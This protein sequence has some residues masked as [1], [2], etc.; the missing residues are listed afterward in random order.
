MGYA[1]GVVVFARSRD[2]DPLY[3]VGHCHFDVEFY[4]VGEWV[5]LDVSRDSVS[6]GFV[7]EAA[8]KRE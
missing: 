8:K 6:V 3:Q 4:K 5:K 2:G 7:G 1:G